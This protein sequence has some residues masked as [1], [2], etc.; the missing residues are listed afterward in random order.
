V[1][2]SNSRTNPREGYRLRL[3]LSSLTVC[4]LWP[5]HCQAAEQRN[6]AHGHQRLRERK[7][8]PLVNG[9]PMWALAHFPWLLVAGLVGEKDAAA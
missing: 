1:F 5:D 6:D 4:C 9:G 8:D 2:S 7:E 3:G